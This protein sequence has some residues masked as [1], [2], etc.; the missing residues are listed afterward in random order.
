MYSLETIYT[1]LGDPKHA[2]MVEKIAYNA[3]PA[4]VVPIYLLLTLADHALFI[5][6]HS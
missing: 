3:L 6:E 4:Q 2:D 5:V 1:I